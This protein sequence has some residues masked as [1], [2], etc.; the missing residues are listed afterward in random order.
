MFISY[1]H[2]KKKIE[3]YNWRELKSSVDDV[4]TAKMNLYRE[5]YTDKVGVK[6]WDLPIQTH[7]GV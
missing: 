1:I 5:V 6:A 2:L 3:M 4:P 7:G